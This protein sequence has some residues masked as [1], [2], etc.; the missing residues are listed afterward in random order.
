MRKAD[1]ITFTRRAG[2]EALAAEYKK[3][4]RSLV[5]AC[6]DVGGYASCV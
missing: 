6:A 4:L 5:F 1:R 2:P 3:E